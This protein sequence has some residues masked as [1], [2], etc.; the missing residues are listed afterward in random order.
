MHD[1]AVWLSETAPSVFIQN[2]SYAILPVIQSIHILAIGI[3]LGS[4]LM[5]N[6]RI[7]GWAG[8][9]RTLKQ[10]HQRFGPW[11]K[12]AL[13]VLLVTGMIMLIGEPVRELF[14]FSFWAKM[15]LV[16][17]GTVIAILFERSLNRNE[18]AWEA[19]GQPGGLK[20]L[21]SITLCIWVMVVVLGR[22]IA[23]DHLW[24]ALSP[25]SHL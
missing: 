25:A 4:V 21:A 12:W 20:L 9:D 8:A 7:F 22:L 15:A 1:F 23:Y 10:V 24:G 13:I 14:A 11:Q 16:L 18:A 19:G 5:L 17:I 2:H 6:L 3:V